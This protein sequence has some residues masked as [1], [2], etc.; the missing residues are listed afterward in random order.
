[1]RLDV[2]SSVP[3]DNASCTIVIDILVEMLRTMATVTKMMKL[4][5]IGGMC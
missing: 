2:A 1:M 3:S 4:N 5:K